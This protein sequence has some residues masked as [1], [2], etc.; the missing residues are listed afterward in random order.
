[1][2]EIKVGNY[3]KDRTTHG[4]SKLVLVY[5]PPKRGPFTMSM[6]RSSLQHHNVAKTTASLLR[7]MSDL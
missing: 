3:G 7:K 4:H 1:M 6:M 5:D 2:H